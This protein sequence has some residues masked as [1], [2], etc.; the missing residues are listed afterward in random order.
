MGP[1]G[2]AHVLPIA[3]A[4]A[5]KLTASARSMLGLAERLWRQG[6]FDTSLLGKVGHVFGA[7]PGLDGVTTD[8]LAPGVRRKPGDLVA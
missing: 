5:K 6:G 8:T 2:C 7:V 4:A 1:A 3:P